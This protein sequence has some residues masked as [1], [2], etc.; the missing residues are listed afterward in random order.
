MTPYHK[1]KRTATLAAGTA[2]LLN[3]LS[4]QL[5]AQTSTPNAASADRSAL[6]PLRS[7]RLTAHTTYA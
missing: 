3:L 1:V 2:L 5:A 6:N 7:T 4:T